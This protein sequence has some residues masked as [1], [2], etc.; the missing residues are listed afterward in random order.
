MSARE[1]ATTLLGL[2]LALA[3]CDG[4]SGPGLPDAGGDRLVFATFDPGTGRWGGALAELDGGPAREIPL[5]VENPGDHPDI[6][7][8]HFQWSPDGRRIAYRASNT[9]TDNWYL[10]LGDAVGGP[11]R[12]LTPLGGYMADAAW[13]PAGDR[14]LYH[15]GGFVG[16]RGGQTI[17]TALVDTLGTRTDFFI[18]G[19]GDPFEGDRVFFGLL[20]IADSSGFVP[21]LYEAAWAPDGDHLL[22][23]GTIGK[24]AWDPELQPEEVELFRVSTVTRRVMERVTRN[25][26]PEWGFRLAPDGRHLL[27]TVRHQRST[28]HP[29]EGEF[30]LPVAGAAADLVQFAELLEHAPLW[31]S[32]SRHITFTRA[33]GP[34]GYPDIFVYDTGTRAER[35]TGVSGFW[36]HLHV[37]GRSVASTGVW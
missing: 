34:G 5:R 12:L 7:F 2:V 20:P 4:P 23:V 15:W 13:S 18:D 28:W 10:V 21:A 3:S 32:D 37:A 8:F 24:R 14:L 16:G 17:Q 30:V 31:A 26:V 6:S 33:T 1:S 27:L 29:V 25:D 36:P 35:A 11:K 19:D 22:V 9:N